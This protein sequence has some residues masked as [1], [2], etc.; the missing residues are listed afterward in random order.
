MPPPGPRKQ[1]AL[2]RYHSPRSNAAR[3]LR[4]LQG[5]GGGSQLLFNQKRACAWH[6]AR[7]D[8]AP[9]PSSTPGSAP[10]SR[11]KLPVVLCRGASSEYSAG[12]GKQ[13]ARV[14]E[15]LSLH[16]SGSSAGG[17]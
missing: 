4:W 16:T 17:G 9:L 10:P 15:R 2:A 12:Q 14:K 3:P 8:D 7:V 5:A 6:A 1:P 11:A 13:W